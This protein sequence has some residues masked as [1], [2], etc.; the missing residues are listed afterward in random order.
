MMLLLVSM[1]FSFNDGFSSITSES[2]TVISV[3][4]DVGDVVII[5]NMLQQSGKLEILNACTLRA[6]DYPGMTSSFSPGLVI[7]HTVMMTDDV[8]TVSNYILSSDY[9][10]MK[11]YYDRDVLTSNNSTKLNGVRSQDY[12]VDNTNKNRLVSGGYGELW[13]FM[14]SPLY[15]TPNVSSFKHLFG[16]GGSGGLCYES[17][18]R[19][20]IHM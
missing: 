11:Y 3:D 18:R 2:S 16:L 9:G 8:H 14:N 13:E 17:S 10:L 12:I 15:C 6:I 7:N 1:L 5:D 20:N 19:V 4:V